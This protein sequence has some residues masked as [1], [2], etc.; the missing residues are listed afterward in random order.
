MS[1]CTVCQQPITDFTNGDACCSVAC[2]HK[3]HAM[4]IDAEI[5]NDIDI[6]TPN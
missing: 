1:L 6:P 5:D 3:L 4:F 2:I